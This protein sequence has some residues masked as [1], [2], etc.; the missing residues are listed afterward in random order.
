[1]YGRFAILLFADGVPSHKVYI[2]SSSRTT[3][4]TLI[5]ETIAIS[6]PPEKNSVVIQIRKNIIFIL[7]RGTC[8]K[9]EAV[10]GMGY[11]GDSSGLVKI[12]HRHIY[13]LTRFRCYITVFISSPVF[14]GIWAVVCCLLWCN[15]KTRTI[16]RIWC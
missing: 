7:G 3:D 14:T 1:M 12:Q 5:F 15:S 13:I 16:N 10:Y 8:I 6:L 11:D 2:P 9:D 4:I